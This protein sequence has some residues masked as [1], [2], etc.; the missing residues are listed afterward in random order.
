MIVKLNLFRHGS[1]KSSISDDVNRRLVVSFTGRWPQVFFSNIHIS[2]HRDIVIGK[3]KSGFRFGVIFK[4]IINDFFYDCVFELFKI[5]SIFRT[6]SPNLL[7]CI[8]IE[9]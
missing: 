4:I 2:G 9:A 8:D 6:E 3:N 7:S 5:N 1:I